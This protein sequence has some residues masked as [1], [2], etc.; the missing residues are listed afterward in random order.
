MDIIQHGYL[1]FVVLYIILS[2]YQF[3][4]KRNKFISQTYR[5]LYPYNYIIHYAVTF[6][7][8]FPA[9]LFLNLVKICFDNIHVTYSKHENII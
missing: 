9:I 5:I 3:S 6:N 4:Q 7:T 2:F 1:R 8:S